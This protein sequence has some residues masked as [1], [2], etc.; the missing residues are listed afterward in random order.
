MISLERARRPAATVFVLACLLAGV[1][2]PAAAASRIVNGLDSQDFPTTGA[3]LY[4]GGGN[5]SSASTMCSGTLIGCRTFLTAAH[6][7]YDD[8]IASHYWVY[9]Q[10]GGIL[11][12]SSVT[13]SPLYNPAN[14]GND[15]AIVR[16]AEPVSGLDPTPFNTTH[17]LDALGVGLGGVI[18]GFGQ[19]SGAGNDYGIKR[20]GDVITADCDPDITD[21]EG[22]DVLVCWNFEAPVGPAGEDSNTCNGDSGGPLFMDFAGVTEVVGVTSAGSS[23]DCLA[24]DHSWDASVYH[25]AAWITAQ[26]G[27]DSTGACGGLPAVG[28]GNVLVHKNGGSLSSPG[29]PEDTWEFELSGT[30]NLVRFALNGTDNGTFNPDLFVKEGAGA[31]PMDFDCQAVGSSMY[32]A[33]E[34]DG[35]AAGTWSVFVRRTNGSGNYQLTTTVFGGDPPVCGNNLVEYG[36]QCD[37]SSDSACDGLCLGGC[38]CPAPVC[39]NDVVESGEQCDGA[40]DSA[41]P[42]ECQ[43]DCS[44]FEPCTTGDLYGLAF[45]SDDRRFSYK[46]LLFD[47]TSAWMDLDPRTDEFRLDV[48]DVGGSVNLAIPA[49]HAGWVKADP[50]RRRYIWKGDGSLVGLRRVKLIYRE[51]SAGTWW[52]LLVKGKEV[53]GG[54]SINPANVLDFELGFGGTC[55]QE[56]W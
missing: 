50:V 46:G 25:N 23:T 48:V 2:S 39:G 35:P 43:G 19:T 55:H 17:D 52:T 37:G 6:C 18:A 49:A 44:C 27:A 7:V 8:T 3:L 34:F 12:A 20:Y 16:F 21:G 54:A 4:S 47:G 1:G 32:G 36:E 51:K 11:A 41:C 42:G 30:P 14:S 31:S 56:T 10:H 24:T 38:T 22:N 28:D 13:Y 15:V 33:C 9:L 40:S 26:L 53:P 29:N 45:L 5:V